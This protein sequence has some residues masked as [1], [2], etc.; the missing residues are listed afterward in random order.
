M[1]DYTFDLNPIH[2][3][4]LHNQNNMCKIS[5]PIAGRQGVLLFV[6]GFGIFLVKYFPM[7][8]ETFNN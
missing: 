3:K 8:T 6:P 7:H 5:K 1:E 2:H 4:A